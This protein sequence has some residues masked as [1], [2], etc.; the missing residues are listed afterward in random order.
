M[1][2]SHCFMTERWKS[3]PPRI[4][5]AHTPYSR[6]YSR[7]VHSSAFRRLQSKTQVYGLGDGDFYRTL[8]THSIEVQQ[9]AWSIVSVLKSDESTQRNGWEQFLPRS[10]LLDLHFTYQNRLNGN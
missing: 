6:D 3:E 2:E 4:N 5:D 1:I 10:N 9:I 7:L 8:L